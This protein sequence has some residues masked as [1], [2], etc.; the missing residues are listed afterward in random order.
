MEIYFITLKHLN[1][2]SSILNRNPSQFLYVIIFMILKYL[3]YPSS[4][5]PSDFVF[6]IFL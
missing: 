2:L 3:N 6:S 5:N 1:Y 4:I